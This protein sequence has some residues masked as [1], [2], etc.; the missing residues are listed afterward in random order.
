MK[1]NASDYLLVYQDFFDWILSNKHKFSKLHQI[2][3]WADLIVC[4]STI[5][6]TYC[7]D[8]KLFSEILIYKLQY[9][10]NDTFWFMDAPFTIFHGGSISLTLSFHHQFFN[11]IQLIL[12][13]FVRKDDLM[14]F[15]L[16]MNANKYLYWYISTYRKMN[17]L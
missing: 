10:L 11:S 7:L 14:V 15:F 9:I 16:Y 6:A 5:P 2:S 12:K 4:L 13:Q 8:G 3:D 17:I 1:A